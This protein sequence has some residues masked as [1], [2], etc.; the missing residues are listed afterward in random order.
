MH[1]LNILNKILITRF[2]FS[3]DYTRIARR[4]VILS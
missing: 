4:H 2:F 3:P 1:L